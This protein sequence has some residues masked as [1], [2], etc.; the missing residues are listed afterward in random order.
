MQPIGGP[1]RKPIGSSP[2]AKKKTNAESSTIVADSA[3]A[4]AVEKMTVQNE[5]VEATELWRGHRDELTDKA[6]TLSGEELQAFVAKRSAELITDKIAEMLIY[7]KASLR[8][9]PEVE[10]RV[11]AYIDGEIRKIVTA[12]YDG[13]Q[14][15]YEKYLES[16]GTNLDQVRNRYRRE[17]VIA[18]YLE[19]EVRPKVAEPTRADLVEAFASNKETWVRPERRSMSLIDIRAS[20]LLPAGVNEPTRE[21]LA[22]AREEARTR[23]DAALVEVRGGGDFAELAKR[24]SHGANASEG[25]KWGWVNAADVRER[26]LPAVD[27]LGKLT[28][29]QTSNVIETPDGFF[30]VR[31]DEFEPAF[32]PTFESVQPQ[33]KEYVSRRLYNH[34]VNEL[35]TELRSKA[36]IEPANLD[37]FHASV[38]ASGLEMVGSVRSGG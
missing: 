26:F 10:K 3:K 37:R 15:R 17:F 33:L 18:G 35:I 4:F 23:A 7:Q 20:D 12:K 6:K 5:T 25:G 27:A 13:L 36:R 2:S 22:A 30:I 21:Q 14:R 11:D 16:Q 28:T 19:N 32:V 29:G 8:Q 1:S 34:L 31:C 24:Y 9:T 38:V